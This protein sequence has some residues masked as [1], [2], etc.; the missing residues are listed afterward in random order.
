LAVVLVVVA[1]TWV[2][3]RPVVLREETVVDVLDGD[4][5][6]LQ[7][8]GERLQIRLY[9]VDCPERGQPYS[10]RA[11]EFTRSVALNR[12]VTV[13]IRDEDPYGRL[14]SEVT[15]PDG[16]VLNQLLV[17]EGW[18]WWY[19]HH[20]EGDR[21]LARLEEEARVAGR[22]LWADRDPTPPWDYRAARRAE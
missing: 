2:A 14:V 4:S 3:Q 16:R 6:V 7:R 8:G 1:G 11:R 9:G 10:A 20:A 15:L 17:G 19:R 5:L 12:R 13:A 22:G 21:V 18:A